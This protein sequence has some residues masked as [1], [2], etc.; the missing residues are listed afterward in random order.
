M[1]FKAAKVITH[2]TITEDLWL[3]KSIGAKQL[4]T[5]TR[6]NIAGIRGDWAFVS[7]PGSADMVL[8]LDGDT[9]AGVSDGGN[10]MHF[11]ADTPVSLGAV[12]LTVV[13]IPVDS[14]E[15]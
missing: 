10:I 6:I 13:G 8:A 4:A 12:P 5:S 7:V 1:T 15:M 3:W 2:P 9:V 14:C 11:G